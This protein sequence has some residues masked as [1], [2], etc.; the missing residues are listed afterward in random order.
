MMPGALLHGGSSRGHAGERKTQLDVN[1]YLQKSDRARGPP[2]VGAS[3]GC[4]GAGA[5]TPGVGKH[6]ARTRWSQELAGDAAKT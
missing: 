1:L 5:Q 6:G 4:L 3:A 2:G